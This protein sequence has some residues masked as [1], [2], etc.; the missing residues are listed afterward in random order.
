[1][2]RYIVKANHTGSQVRI[3]LPVKLIEEMKWKKL[4]FF[5]LEKQ[6]RY[7]ITIKRAYIGGE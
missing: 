7:T 4:S 2:D 1:M 5:V 3:N 6:G